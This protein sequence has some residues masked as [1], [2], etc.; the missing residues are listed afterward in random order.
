MDVRIWEGT[1]R[2]FFSALNTAGIT[3]CLRGSDTAA[4]VGSAIKE[5]PCIITSE[6]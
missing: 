4:V 3:G 5:R 1:V 2:F 6:T